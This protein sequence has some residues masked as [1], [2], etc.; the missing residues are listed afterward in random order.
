MT[1]TNFAELIRDQRQ[2][3]TRFSPKM[4]EVP[5]KRG[6]TGGPRTTKAILLQLGPDDN[7]IHFSDPTVTHAL[8]ND[9]HMTKAIVAIRKSTI[10]DNLFDKITTQPKAFHDYIMTALGVANF[11]DE[12]KLRPLRP[13]DIEWGTETTQE[14]R[15]FALLRNNKKKQAFYRSGTQGVFIRTAER[16]EEFV[17]VNLPIKW[18]LAE[19]TALHRR[20]PAGLSEGIVT[21]AKG[22]A[23]RCL[24]AHK[25]DIQQYVRPEEAET[26]G[27]LFSLE[28]DN[29]AQ[30]IV[31]GVDN[32]VTGPM[33]HRS[34]H[35]SIGW[36][37]KPVKPL[38][39]AAWGKRD[40]IVWAAL[41]DE[42]SSSF[43]C[44]TTEAGSAMR[45]EI[46]EQPFK[47]KTSFWQKIA[48]NLAEKESEDDMDGMDYVDADDDNDNN[49]AP[50][51]PSSAAAAFPTFPPH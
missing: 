2:L 32:E 29:A 11:C 13:K 34:L 14:V 28:Q 36:D 1:G 49:A 15:G 41:N 21:T 5:V 10:P 12:N 30:Y 27:D 44:L 18:T 8:A 50:T 3:V 20:L 38:R 26:Y 39:S 45:I 47:A 17:I 16:D 43:L 31:R 6:N 40:W 23:I 33:L 37:V 24:P 51:E 4:I 35:N 25:D 48:D 42:P 19:A 22:Y 46:D 7:H 9:N